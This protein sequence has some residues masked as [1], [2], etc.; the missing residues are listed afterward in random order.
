MTRH[1][2]QRCSACPSSAGSVPD[3]L[4]CYVAAAASVAVPIGRVL[5]REGRQGRVDCSSSKPERSRYASAG[6]GRDYVSAICAE[7]IASAKWRLL[8]PLSP[9]CASPVLRRWRT[10][11]RS[12]FR[13]RASSA[14]TRPTSTVAFRADEHCASQLS[15]RCARPT[16]GRFMARVGAPD[17]GT[18]PPF[19]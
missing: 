19:S 17:P 9:D 7:A 3:V 18:E 10:A 1:G 4:A 5:F 15:R 8:D 11:P 16:S 12:S 6:D 14:S 13:P 2:S